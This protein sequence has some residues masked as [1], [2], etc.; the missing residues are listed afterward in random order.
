MINKYRRIV[1]EVRHYGLFE[2][3][4][5]KATEFYYK[6]KLKKIGISY[7]SENCPVDVLNHLSL[8]KDAM[9][10]QATAFYA[11]KRGFDF[12]GINYS[13]ICLLDIGCGYGKVL[14]FGMLKD[15][16]RVVGVD[17]D[18]N[19]IEIAV[20]NSIKMKMKGFKTPFSYQN[21]D[22]CQFT[23]PEDINVIF[24]ANP[25]G[26][27]TMVEVMDKIIKFQQFYNREFFVIYSVPV[28]QEVLDCHEGCYKIFESF[29]ANKTCSEM[30]IFKIR[31]N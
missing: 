28:H 6:K 12:T 18:N 15:F 14:N 7:S 17:L 27:A 10:N 29:N 26:K 23:I 2:I 13:N 19:A 30:A 8:N 22:A 16:K 3:I 21:I 20:A 5:T 11:I 24:M 31:K 9:L 4:K 1:K 25:F